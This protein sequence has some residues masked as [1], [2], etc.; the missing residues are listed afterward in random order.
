MDKDDTKE[1]RQEAASL[2]IYISR[3]E[4]VSTTFIRPVITKYVEFNLQ[5]TKD[6]CGSNRNSEA[7]I[8][9]FNRSLTYTHGEAI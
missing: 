2:P 1:S 6:L 5:E 7:H 3:D 8:S 4:N 9:R